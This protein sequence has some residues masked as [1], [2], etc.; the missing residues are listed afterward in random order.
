MAHTGMLVVIILASAG[1]ESPTPKM[2]LPWLNTMAS[3]EAPK[4]RAMS[5]EV[6][7]SGFCR[8]EMSQN[9]SI[10][11][12]MRRSVMIIGVTIPPA[13]TILAS[14]DINPQ[15]TLASNIAP[16]PLILELSIFP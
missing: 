3:S 2:K 1:D 13:I 5:C 9:S 15:L 7:C 8:S 12:H 11:P 16:C 6:T 14:G 10:A 4:S